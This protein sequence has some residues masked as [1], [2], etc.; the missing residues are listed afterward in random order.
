MNKLGLFLQ[1]LKFLLMAN[2][3]QQKESGEGSFQ[4]H[5]RAVKWSAFLSRL[6]PCLPGPLVTLA[7]L[8]LGLQKGAHNSQR[9]GWS[10]VTGG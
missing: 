9:A 8:L 2:A 6:L 1:K 5:R 7:F 10:E 4:C 3:E